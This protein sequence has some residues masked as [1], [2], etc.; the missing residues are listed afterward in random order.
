MLHPP[1]R[2]DQVLTLGTYL[3]ITAAIA[4]MMAWYNH[5]IQLV[6]R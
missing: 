4:G 2:F 6:E 1:S 3:V 5:R